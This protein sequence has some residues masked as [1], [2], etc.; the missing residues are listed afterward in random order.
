MFR[1]MGRE[2]LRHGRLAAST[3]HSIGRSF[4]K[5]IAIHSEKEQYIRKYAKDSL[6]MPLQFLTDILNELTV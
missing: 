3:I 4:L 5:R 1:R 2:G 6:D